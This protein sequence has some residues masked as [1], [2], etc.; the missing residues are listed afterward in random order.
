MQILYMEQKPQVV[1]AN[2]GG[3]AVVVSIFSLL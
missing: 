1:W 2:K 3:S